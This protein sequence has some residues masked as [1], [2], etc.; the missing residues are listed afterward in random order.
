M[1]VPSTST[2]H[3]LLDGHPVDPGRVTVAPL[4]RGRRPRSLPRPPSAVEAVRRRFG[5]DGPYALFVGGI[6]PRKNLEALVR[7]FATLRAGHAARHRRA[8]RSAGTRKAVDRLSETIAALP[9]G[10]RARIVQTGYVSDKD[11]VPLLTGATLL[12]YPSLYEGFGFPV[13]EAFAAGMPVLTSNVSS[14]PEVAGDAA[15]L[16]DPRDEAAIAA[17]L[18]Q[19]FARRRSASRAV[20]RRPRARGD[21]H[22]GGHREADR[23]G[24]APRPRPDRRVDSRRPRVP[25]GAP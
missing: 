22:V 20:G 7:A 4:G 16:V 19:L 23:R 15:V 17:G 1:L 25:R 8:G 5:I 2:R 12:A 11:K 18:A 14:L 24:A 21:L 10:A 6:E 9:A 3:D 13:L